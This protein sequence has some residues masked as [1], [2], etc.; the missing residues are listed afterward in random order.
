[1]PSLPECF[2]Q[3]ETKAEALDNIKEAIML[4]IEDMIEAGEEVPAD[5]GPISVETVAV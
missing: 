3:G 2:S 1:V 5:T 4:Y